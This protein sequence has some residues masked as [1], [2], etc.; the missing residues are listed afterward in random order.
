MHA[1]NFHAKSSYARTKG[2]RRTQEGAVMRNDSFGRF[3]KAGIGSIAMCEGKTAPAIEDELGE[4]IGVSAATIQR[5]KTGYMPRESRTIQ[6]LAEAV[7]K[8]GYLNREWL[9][10]F[11]GA[12]RYPNPHPLLEQLC[13]VGPPH[14]RPARIYTN[15]PAPLYNQFVMRQQAYDEV[16]DGLQQRSAMVLIMSLGGMG[17]TS[18]AREIAAHCLRD[19]ALPSFDAAV[20]VSDKDRPGTTTLSRLLDEIVR[21]LDYPGFT[22]FAHEEKQR[23]VEQLLRRQRV[24]LIVDNFETITD[25]ALLSW[26][27]RLPEP[28]KAIVTTREYQRGYRRNCWPVELRGMQEAEAEKLIRQRLRT[29]KIERLISDPAQLAPLIAGT[30]GNPKAIEVALGCLKYERWPIQQIVDDLESARGELFDDLFTRSWALLD[31]AARRVLLALPLF[32][33]SASVEALQMTADVRGLPF[34]RAIECLT[35]L[36]LIDVHQADLASM[37]RYALHPLVRAFAQARLAEQ[38]T[39]EA[40]ARDRWVDWYLQLTARVGF[41]WYDLPRL[42]LLDSEHET[43]HTVVTWAFAQGRYDETIKLIEGVRYYY[44]VRGLWDK[45]LRMNLIRA[46]AARQIGDRGNEVLGLAYHVEILSKQ[47]LLTEATTYLDRLPEAAEILHLPGDIAFEVQHARALYA[48]AQRDLRTAQQL[49]RDLLA[50][51]SQLGGQK[52]AVNRRWLAISLYEQGQLDEAQQLFQEAEADARQIQDQRSVTGNTIKL[53]IIDLDRGKLEHAAAA[54]AESRATAEHY[55]DRRRLAE[56][57][58][59]AARLYLLRGDRAAVAALDVA[60]DLF[61]RMGMRQELA[62][63]RTT[64]ASLSI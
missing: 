58:R 32:P 45:R 52:Y 46:E 25:G 51:S 50:L 49:W 64:Q 6:L 54:L 27:L 11:L 47:G 31:E 42:A 20:W 14:P 2:N 5:Y 23:E 44:N 19:D 29:L 3:L 21:T 35:D 7:V 12:A 55:Q 18:L 1:A 53:A 13:P 28:S 43:I 37:P 30:G 63:A 15:L 41:C 60:I 62:E 56:I 59:A 24:L 10:H 34:N 16:L 36:A 48:R 8:R 22:Q 40:S 9:Q 39:F 33:A 4:R 38:T 57:Y 26:L 17:K 61:E